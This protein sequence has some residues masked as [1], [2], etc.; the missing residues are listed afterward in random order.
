[1]GMEIYGGVGEWQ[2]V[3]K[4]CKLCT[5]NSEIWVKVEISSSHDIKTAQLEEFYQIKT[6]FFPSSFSPS[7]ILLAGKS[8]RVGE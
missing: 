5:T 7:D 1:M 6:F 3:V 2:R 8:G 4:C